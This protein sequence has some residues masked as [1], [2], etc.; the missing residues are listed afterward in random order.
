MGW[1]RPSTSACIPES[2]RGSDIVDW[3]GRIE[4]SI[5]N[6]LRDAEKSNNSTYEARLKAFLETWQ[7]HPID[8]S[9]NRETIEILLAAAKQWARESWDLQSYFL[10]LQTRLR[11]LIASEEELPRDI[12]MGQNDAALGGGGGGGGGGGMPPMSPSFGP[13]DG[14]PEEPGAEGG[15]GPGDLG[16]GG[17]GG[18][19][20]LGGP[21]G[22]L[23]DELGAESPEGLGGEAPGPDGEEPEETEE[24]I[25]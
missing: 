16:A 9:L 13:Q 25:P 20:D 14:G 11:Q 6:L 3:Y 22:D 21:E 19:G 17:P 5:I 8:G 15:G 4:Q 10:S 23:P 18:P 1:V 24:P 7:E 12:D 2:Y